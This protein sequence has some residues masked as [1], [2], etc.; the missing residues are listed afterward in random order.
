MSPHGTQAAFS[1][2]A[3]QAPLAGIDIPPFW[4]VVLPGR[5]AE[6]SAAEGS[7]VCLVVRPGC[8]F[9]DGTHPTTQLCLQAIAALAPRHRKDWRMLDFG[10][11]SGI[12]AIAAAKLG[13]S[14]S[15]VE[16]D[17]RA[18]GS[19]QENARLSGVT[20]RLRCART[21]ELGSG[22]FELV[23]ANVVRSVLLDFSGKLVSS[24]APGASLVLS[25]L[26]ST[27]VPEVSVRYASLLAAGR[28]E[29]H[30]R[31]EWRTLVWRSISLSISC[32]A[33]CSEDNSSSSSTLWRASFVPASSL[34]TEA[35]LLCRDWRSNS[36]SCSSACSAA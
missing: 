31:G 18:L 21:L 28:P 16:I 22:R 32:L 25:G 6:G 34:R 12:L 17:D 7:K 1:A 8:G 15:A 11:G 13:A 27:D 4:R 30:E 9:G 35:A 26:V 14:V 23:V 19:A 10:S 20:D 2:T 5:A 3:R 36:T 33:A 29:I 24:L